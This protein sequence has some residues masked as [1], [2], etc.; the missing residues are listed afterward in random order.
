VSQTSSGTIAEMSRMTVENR[1]SR[2]YTEL[3][4]CSASASWR[5]STMYHRPSRASTARKPTPIPA[6]W[7]R[8]WRPSTSCCGSRS[9]LGAPGRCV[10]G[11]PQAI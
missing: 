1:I 9:I 5:L 6:R 7:R 8:T 3:R 10:H 4:S 11:V 2:W